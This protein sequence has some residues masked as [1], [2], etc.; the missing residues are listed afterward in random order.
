[1]KKLLLIVFLICPVVFYGQSLVTLEQTFEGQ[2]SLQLK[3]AEYQEEEFD[4]YIMINA[5]KNEI[6]MYHVADYSFYKKVEVTPPD[7]YRLGACI[8]PTRYFFNNDDKFEFILTF[9][10]PVGDSMSKMY[11]Y[12]EDGEI[13]E[14]LGTSY[15]YGV[16][17]FHKISD[18]DK[19]LVLTKIQSASPQTYTTHIY[20]VSKST[21]TNVS[22]N[23][24]NKA[25]NPYPNPSD[26]IINL[27]YELENG[28]KSV[29]QIYDLQGNLI[30]E[31]QITYLSDKVELNVASYSKGTYICKVKDVSNKFIV[32]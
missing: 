26:A 7:G 24:N 6:N 21:T 29:M 28:E 30:E 3:Y 32:N 31:K 5:P 27:P 18:D 4:Y 23:Q 10:G 8:A 19:R 25:Q 2:F 16:S 15:S 13:L 12:N 1:M 20:S 22:Q 11:L 17:F 9:L 14:D